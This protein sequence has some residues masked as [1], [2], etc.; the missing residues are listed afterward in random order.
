MRFLVYTCVFGGYDR[1][2][3]PIQPESNLDYVII[4]D[5]PSLNVQGWQTQAVQIHTFPTLKAANL[6]HRALI[7]RILSNYD[8]SVY[9]DG[10]IRLCGRLSQLL[11]SFQAS[12]ADLAAYRHPLRSTVAGEVN[13]CIESG[14]VGNPDSL[15]GELAEYLALGFPDDIGLVETGVL[16]KNH[17]SA[18]LDAAMALWWEL[19][20]SHLTRDQISLPYVLWKTGLSVYNLPGS[21][22]DMNP[23]FALYPHAMA[24]GVNPLYSHV[25]ARSH[26]SLIHRILLLAW[27]TSWNI[28]RAVRELK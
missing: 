14:K 23:Y 5:D 6:Y 20:A 9:I 28:Q 25:S 7:H 27:H 13:A 3:P 2:Y 26:D 11:E 19:Y 8:T 12:G 22:R 15:R 10:N 4:T 24:K 17:K 16:L 18:D 1:I 21:L